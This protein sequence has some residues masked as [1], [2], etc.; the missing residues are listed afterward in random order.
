MDRVWLPLPHEV[1]IIGSLASVNPVTGLPYPDER[2]TVD[3]D[4][5]V[6]DYRA[7]AVGSTQM[8]GRSI[9]QQN[10]IALLQV[11]QANPMMAQIVNWAN[12]ARQTFDLFDF[13]NIDELLV[14]QVPAVNALAQQSGQSPEQVAGTLSQPLETL[15]PGILGQYTNQ[16]SQSP[17][18]MAG[19]IG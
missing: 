1:R 2:A 14:S 17:I 18:S 8:V 4:D 11:L 3:Y 19:M 13:R 16:Q 12:F 6:P 10:W 15:S 7:R 5:L 9:R